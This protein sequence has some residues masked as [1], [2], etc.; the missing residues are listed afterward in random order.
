MKG[1]EALRAFAV[2]NGKPLHPF[3]EIAAGVVL[4]IHYMAYLGT[5]KIRA[6]GF[7]LMSI[8]TLA[9]I[10]SFFPLELWTNIAW[11]VVAGLG[12]LVVLHLRQLRDRHFNSWSA[13]AE[14]PFE[15]AVP[16]VIVIGLLMLAG[17]AV[18]RAPVLLE[19][20]YTLWLQ[21]RNK[22]VPAF[23]GE[24][25]YIGGGDSDGTGSGGLVQVRLRTKRRQD[26]RRLRIRLFARHDGGHEPE[27]LL[28]RR[29][30][31]DLYRSGMDRPQRHGDD[32]RVAWRRRIAGGQTYARGD[33]NERGYADV[34]YFAQ[35]PASRPVRRG[36]D[37]RPCRMAGG[38]RQRQT[39]MEQGRAGA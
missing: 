2:A 37:R 26:R 34:P 15:L 5:N 31:G 1:W 8:A 27:G 6:I 13:L 22:E 29:D 14:R 38:E 17:I 39:D 32:T 24:G 12:W 33:R 30:E 25:G 16:A 36:S 35:R 3:F 9:I 28:A 18:P 20:P 11:A 21:A 19:D 4:I 10:D 7:I 23:S